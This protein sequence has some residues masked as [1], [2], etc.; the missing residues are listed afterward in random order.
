M[1]RDVSLWSVVRS[2]WIKFRS[3]RST[4]IGVVVTFVLTIGLG[5]LVTSLIRAHWNTTGTLQKATFDPVATSLVGVLFAQFAVG[6]IGSL[7]ITSEFSS[8]SIRTTL[9]AVPKRFELALGKLI[10]LVVSMFVVA[11][12]ACFA[13]FSLGQAIFSGV[14]PTAS[15]SNGTVLRA[16][17]FAGLYLTLLSVLA[18]SLGLLLRQ[19]AACISVFVSVLLIVPIILAFFPQSWQNDA[20]RFL[21]SEMGH[22][23]ISTASVPNDFGPTT[24]LIVLVIYV[25]VVFGAGLAVFSRRD[26]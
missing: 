3:V 12:A 8:G 26:A 17:F 25:A 10:V 13:T 18:L 1:N 11:E 9:T 22:A 16:V 14:V 15:L 19:S 24:A 2:E 6:V 23:M 7:F 20:R 5:A 21:P 4:I